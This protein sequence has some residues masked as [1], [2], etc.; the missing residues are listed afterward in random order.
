[1]PT[2]AS[3]EWKRLIDPV[4]RLLSFESWILILNQQIPESKMH[5]IKRMQFLKL[6]RENSLDN[7]RL[8]ESRAVHGTDPVSWTRHKSQ[9]RGIIRRHVNCNKAESC[10]CNIDSQ[11]LWYSG[12]PDKGVG[13][14]CRFQDSSKPDTD[15]HFIG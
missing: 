15:S 1:M 2:V 3:N 6:Q 14:F 9:S 8:V 10:R 5:N 11:S 7:G 13:V 12:L 4:E